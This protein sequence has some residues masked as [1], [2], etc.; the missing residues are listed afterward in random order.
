MNTPNW[1][2]ARAECTL[3][4]NFADVANAIRKDVERF[5]SLSPSNR[6]DR[7]FLAEDEEDRL[8]VRRAVRVTNSRGSHILPD[9][10]YFEDF[11]SVECR[12]GAI[13]AQR[14]DRF[15]LTVYPR[16]NADSLTCDLYIGDQAFPLWNISERILEPF[17]EITEEVRS[18]SQSQV[19]LWA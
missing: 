16:W 2:K 19:N 18:T 5:N 6:G 12:D 9:Q 7:L 14:Q 4:R 13:V 10:D 3:Q 8:E 15:E 1:V 11:I 17:L